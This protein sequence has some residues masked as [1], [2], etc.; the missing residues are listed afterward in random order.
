MR[1]PGSQG[2]KEPNRENMGED[3]VRGA[4]RNLTLGLKMP[5][6]TVHSEIAVQK[7]R[8]IGLNH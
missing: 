3:D 8:T 6:G 4:S 5:Q 7:K 1:H 2:G